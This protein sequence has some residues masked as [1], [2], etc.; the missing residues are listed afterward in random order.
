[1]LSYL[2]YKLSINLTFDTIIIQNWI[3]YCNPIINMSMSTR[4][5]LNPARIEIKISDNGNY[6]DVAIFLDNKDVL[7]AVLTIRKDWTNG[8]LIDNK[9][10]DDFINEDRNS[11]DTMKFWLNYKKAIATVKNL[12]YGMT[13]VPPF[14][15]AILSGVVTDKDYSTVI[16]ELPLHN[17]PE[18]ITFD[19][20]VIYFSGKIRDK[21]MSKIKGS[22]DTKAIATV[23]RDRD[24]YWD[25]EYKHQGY[26]TIAKKYTQDWFTVRSAIVSYKRRLGSV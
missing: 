17:S 19:S 18:D 21:D 22:R 16:K 9:L 24:W 26:R 6:F 2:P 12:R 1:M 10:I 15:A 4:L 13:Y 14:I 7:K 20:P 8:L 23:K 5:L 3:G 11:S 25:H